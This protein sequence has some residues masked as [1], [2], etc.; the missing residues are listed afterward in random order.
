MKDKTKY[1]P[2]IINNL[3]Q[4]NPYKIILFGSHV[5]ESAIEDSDLD[6][7]VILDSPKISKNYD[8]KMRN[9]L[10]VRQKIYDI[11]KEIPIDLVVY[12]NGEYDIILKNRSSFCNE[13]E[14]T[15]KVIYEKT[16]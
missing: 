15:G 5:K 1:L 9:R 12:K 13:V 3:K 7:F 16:D 14:N 11:S 8:E 6:L 4:V 2:N 10:L